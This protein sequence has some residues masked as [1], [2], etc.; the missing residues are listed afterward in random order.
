MNFIFPP[1]GGGVSV[2]LIVLIFLRHVV[3][4]L[5]SQVLYIRDEIKEKFEMD[6]TVWLLNVGK[7]KM[8][9]FC[10]NF[11]HYFRWSRENSSYLVRGVVIVDDILLNFKK[12]EFKKC[13]IYF[14]LF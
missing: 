10:V 4:G 6:S 13:V 7:L 3:D 12:L 9:S 5:R 8:P 2:K 14:V 11:R 1:P